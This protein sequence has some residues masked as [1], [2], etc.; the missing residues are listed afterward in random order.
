VVTV[1]AGVVTA[2]A[3]GL[4]PGLAGL[5]VPGPGG[6]TGIG[7]LAAQ[8][9]A[10]AEL[11]RPMYHP[12]PS[13][14]Q[15][16]LSYLNRLLGDVLNPSLRVRGGWW[17]LLVLLIAAVLIAVIAVSTQRAGR[18]RRLTAAPVRGSRPRSARDHYLAAQRLAGAGEYAD[19]SLECVR[20]IAAELEERQLLP[21]RP[22]RTADEFAAEAGAALPAQAPALRAAATTFDE[23]AYGERPGTLAGYQRLADLA[24]RIGVGGG[25]GGIRP[26]P[27]GSSV[28]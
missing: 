23:I 28:S 5:A 26:E 12:Q 6:G 3:A 13:L 11:A 19:A 25:R 17:A 9:L 21:A 4:L 20:A 27:A 1:S 7:R 8:R 16:V 15:R 10:R 18:S 14:T 2:T 24:A 22:G